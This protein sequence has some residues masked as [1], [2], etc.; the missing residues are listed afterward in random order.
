M[1]CVIDIETDKLHDPTQIWVVVCKD[2]DTGQYHIFRNLTTD[3]EA[4]KRFIEFSD[5]VTLWIG[6]N[7]L[8][9]DFPVLVNLL[10]WSLPRIDWT[11]DTLVISRLVNYSREYGH[12]LASYGVEFELAKIWFSDFTHWS[13]E[14]EDY[15]VRDVDLGHKV[16]LHFLDYIMDPAWLPS[17]TLENKFQVILNS[18]HDHGFAFNSSEATVLLN[19]VKGE[20]DGLDTEIKEV[21]RPKPKP[22]REVHPKLTKYGTLNRSDF[23]FVKDGDL[24]E[25][26]GGPFTRLVYEPFNPAS[27]KQVIEVLNQAGW[28]PTDKTDTHIKTLRELAKCKR[29]RTEEKDLDIAELSAKL[30]KFQKY[31][32]KVNE[33]N[34]ASLIDKNRCLLKLQ[35][36]EE[37]IIVNTIKDLNVVYKRMRTVEN[38]TEQTKSSVISLNPQHLLHTIKIQEHLKTD[39]SGKIIEFLLKILNRCLLNNKDVARFVE[40]E[41]NLWLIIVTPQAMFVDFSASYVMDTLDGLKDLKDQLKNTFYEAPPPARLIAK[42]ILRESRRRTLTEWL[43]LLSPDGRIHAE[44]AGIGAWT[45]RMA[46]RAPNLANIPLEFDN[47]TGQVKY[48]GKELRSLWVAGKGRLLLGVDADSIQFR[49]AAHYINDPKLTERIVNGRK[50]DK[51]D[52]HSFNKTLFGPVCKT[53]QAAKQ[54]LFSTF[55]GAGIGK[56]AEILDSSRYEAEKALAL[57]LREYPG[58]DYVKRKVAPS[59]AK[60]GYFIGLDGRRVPIP[61]NTI[62]ERKHLAPSGYLQCGEAIIIKLAATHFAPRLDKLQSFLVDIIHDEYQIEVPNKEIGLEVAQIVA[63]S[64]KWAGEELKLNCP[65]AGSYW[66]DDRQDYTMG[67]NWYLT[68]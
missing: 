18:V 61:G 14:M 4:K 26:N 38:V 16:Y 1:K 63:D 64:I 33:N 31:G 27:P 28:S 17:I 19:Q 60:Q 48:L 24:S 68:H 13:Q 2:I 62:D 34:L 67:A 54:F 50:A 23:R 7:I 6:H 29:S 30:I 57:L 44:F 25:Y 41:K 45:M 20:L 5:G 58:I 3:A 10:G 12:S 36:D 55:L 66:N 35:N 40:N 59:D 39:S 42:R 43:S 52:T 65:M 37:N 9:F 32:W 11:I 21:F 56:L 8:E 51:T 49:V 53:R 15:C 22:I 47:A 46:H